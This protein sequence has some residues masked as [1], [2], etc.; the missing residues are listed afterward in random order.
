MDKNPPVL[1]VA[2]SRLEETRKACEAIRLGRPSKV[3]AACDGPRIGRPEDNARCQ[4][5]RDFISAFD[6]GCPLEVR[7]EKSN[8]GCKRAVSAAVQWFFQNERCGIVIEDDIV[9]QPE[10]FDFCRKLLKKY[11]HNKTIWSISGLNPIEKMT[12]EMHEDYYYSK[13]FEVWG[14][15][16]WSDRWVSY[17]ADMK[18]WPNRRNSL[19][20]GTGFFEKLMIYRF[21][22]FFDQTFSG[23]VD[24]WD[25]SR[26]EEQLQAGG[27]TVYPKHTLVT[28]VGFSEQATH[29]SLIQ[30]PVW[31]TLPCG[32]TPRADMKPPA[33]IGPDSR[34]DWCIG[35]T[36]YH[37]GL[38][39]HLKVTYA[40]PVV[41]KL[42]SYLQSRRSRR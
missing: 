28:N 36:R 12:S 33:T 41:R 23:N 17:D 29:T 42:R 31:H 37:A 30:R 9:A 25:Y 27:L 3:Y 35:V 6:F 4:S 32:W 24:T 13:F 20:I 38:L 5:V 15:A 14:W 26:I 10:F 21:R 11:E 34:F 19:K 8:L 2:F 39:N 18:E 40:S 16:S 1:L 7:F 22:H